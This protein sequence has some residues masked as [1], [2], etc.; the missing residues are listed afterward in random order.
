[1]AD[2]RLEE[3]VQIEQRLP[4]MIYSAPSALKCAVALENCIACGGKTVN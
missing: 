1:M 3:D 4:E 2:S